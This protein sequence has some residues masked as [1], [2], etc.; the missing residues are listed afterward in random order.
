MSSICNKNKIGIQQMMAA[1]NEEEEK[2]SKN[3]EQILNYFMR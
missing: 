3:E 1:L 2:G